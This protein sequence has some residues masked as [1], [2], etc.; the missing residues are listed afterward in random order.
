LHRARQSLK[1]HLQNPQIDDADSV[2]Q[3]GGR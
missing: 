3:E 1:R 2:R